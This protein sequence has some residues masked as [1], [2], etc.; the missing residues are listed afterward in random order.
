MFQSIKAIFKLRWKYLTRYPGWLIIFFILPIVLSIIPIILGW[1]IAGSP[2][3]ATINFEKN[4]GTANY[5]LF[6]VLGSLTWFLAI[7]VMWDFG[8]WIREEQE[9]GTLEQLLLTP[10]N[11]IELLIGSFLYAIFNSSMQFI[12]VLCIASVLF[13][14]INLLFSSAM[15]LTVVYLILGV[16]P[17]TGF[18][19]LI[20]C[21]IIKIR[22]AEA[23]IR[24]L[25]PV[26]AFLVGIFYPVTLMP[27]LIRTIALLI[28]LTIS[29]QDMRAVLLNISYV[30]NPQ[31][32]L[33]IL[34]I[35]CALWPLIG[36]KAFSYTEKKARKEGDLSG[37]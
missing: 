12:T 34:L 33:F 1:A 29:L 22:E 23:I 18:A 21:L 25:Q 24:L 5:T 13:N 27:V 7:S 10:T 14:F 9:M 36:I 15:L 4:V 8:M 19:L 28:P 35:Y 16:F 26:I 20:G 6:M 3:Q 32:D 11:P 37:F 31:L 2:Q 17:L 30:F